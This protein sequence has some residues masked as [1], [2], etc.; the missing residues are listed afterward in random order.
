MLWPHTRKPTTAIPTDYQ[1]TALLMAIFW[2]GMTPQETVWLT[3]AMMRSG[4]VIDLTD[5]PGAKVH[6]HST[7]GVGDKVS[8]MLA[9]LLAACGGAVP[10]ISGRGLGHTGGTLDK[11]QAIPGYDVFPDET[12]L[13]AALRG[14]GCAIMGATAEI[15]HRWAGTMG[16]TESGLPMEG[17]LEGMRNVYLCAGFTGHGMGFAFMTAMK[18][19]EKI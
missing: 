11:M 3:D 1:A 13:R 4:D 8:L 18:V 9:P 16:F 15:T 19:A 2:R 5:L 17:P 14:A 10:M 6:K 12:K 7:G